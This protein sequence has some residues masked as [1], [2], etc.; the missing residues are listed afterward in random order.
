MYCVGI[1]AAT[2]QGAHVNILRV[3]SSFNTDGTV[4]PSIT[5]P[6]E[7]KPELNTL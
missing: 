5:A 1:R 7:D 2:I 6:S 3:G 4:G